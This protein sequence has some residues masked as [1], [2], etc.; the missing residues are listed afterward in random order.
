MRRVVTE[1]VSLSLDEELIQAARAKAGR[2][3]LSG[4]VNDAL[5]RQVQRD[6][7]TAFLDDVEREVGPIDEIVMEEVRRA[8]PESP[9]R[10]RQSA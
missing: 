3:G 5:L 2:R 1:K 9:K 10:R 7:L 4:Y 6:R 8:W